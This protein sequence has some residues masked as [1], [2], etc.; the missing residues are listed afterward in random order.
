MKMARQFTTYTLQ[1]IHPNFIRGA[2]AFVLI[3]SIHN[4]NFDA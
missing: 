1:H 3:G 4:T 2:Y